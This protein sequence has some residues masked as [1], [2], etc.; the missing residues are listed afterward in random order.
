VTPS[1]I[2]RRRAA[3]I[4]ADVMSAGMTLR[5]RGTQRLALECLE[6]LIAAWKDS[7]YAERGEP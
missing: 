5:Q 2:A 6:R 3:D 7:F 1:D 4:V